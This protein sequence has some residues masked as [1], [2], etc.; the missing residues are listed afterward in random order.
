[1]ALGLA[2]VV[3]RV[4]VAEVEVL[5]VVVADAF[6]LVF[7]VLTI[8]VF[9]FLTACGACPPAVFRHLVGLASD[10]NSFSS[11]SDSAEDSESEFESECGSASFDAV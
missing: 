3:V 11:M 5:T 7:T 1:M 6:V 8:V 4:V 10:S 9:V 2:F